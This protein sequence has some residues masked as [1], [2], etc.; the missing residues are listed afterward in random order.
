[1]NVKERMVPKY[2]AHGTYGCVMR[3]RI[4]CKNASIDYIGPD[5]TVSKLFSDT[6]QA[7]QEF[8]IHQQSVARIDPKGLFTVKLHQKC[9]ADLVNTPINELNKCANLK[10]NSKN[11][12]LQLIYADGGLSAHRCAYIGIRFMDVAKGMYATF[13]GI[14]ELAKAGLC[15]MD[16]KPTNLV[17]AHAEQTPT[18]RMIDFGLL[19]QCTDVY[20]P[21]NKELISTPYVY[22]PPE[23]HLYTWSDEVTNGKKSKCIAQNAVEQAQY[24]GQILR[25]AEA[26]PEA[27]SLP[28]MSLTN[29]ESKLHLYQY[30][31]LLKI[32]PSDLHMFADRIDVYSLG[33]SITEIVCHYLACRILSQ[34]EQNVAVALLHLALQMTDMNPITRP[35]AQ[36]C[37]RLYMNKI[38]PLVTNAEENKETKRHKIL[39]TRQASKESSLNI[40]CRKVQLLIKDSIVAFYVLVVSMPHWNKAVNRRSVRCWG[41]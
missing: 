2:V 6:T 30:E 34:Q 23:F 20:T 35:T 13:K 40:C 3:P 41:S 12:V 39:H 14:E 19:R 4:P 33:V 17:Y 15:H 37:R 26:V 18:I 1:M 9:Q 25:N 10:L 38:L 21:K 11:D 31:Q 8:D 32:Q 5:D 29:H 16:I 27:I 22:W 7:E 28:L 24:N 36:Q